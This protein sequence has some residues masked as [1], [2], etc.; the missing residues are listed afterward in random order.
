MKL[1]VAIVFLV[2][3]AGFVYLVFK[4]GYIFSGKPSA[5]VQNVQSS[6]DLIRQLASAK[7]RDYE[8]QELRLSE[9]QLTEPEALIVHL[10]ASWCAPCVNEV[11]ELVEYSKHNPQVLFVIVSLD[12]DGADIAKFM[13]SFPE[14]NSDQYIKIWDKDNQLA[15]LFEADRLPMSVVIRKKQQSPQI[16]KSVVDWKNFQ[17]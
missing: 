15:K 13:K 16:I 1:K 12:E 14:F 11:P 9:K 4:G 10:W 2:L 6:G 3:G 5:D 17:I 7:L 8:G